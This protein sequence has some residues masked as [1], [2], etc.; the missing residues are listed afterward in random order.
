MLDQLFSTRVLSLILGI[1]GV[2]AGML[3][4]MAHKRSFE[5]ASDGTDPQTVRF[6]KRKFRRRMIAG[7]MI[8]CAGCLMAGLFWVTEARVFAIFILLILGLLVGILG[9]AI[10]DLFSVSLQTITEKDDQARQA[11]VKEYLKQREK[12]SED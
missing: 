4:V 3:L 1:A 9:I 10:F 12:K 7:T 8:A 5:S 11:M 2:I 6:E